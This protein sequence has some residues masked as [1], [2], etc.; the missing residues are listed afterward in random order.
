MLRGRLI[1]NTAYSLHAFTGFDG[2]SVMPILK[3][4]FVHGAVPATDIE[5]ETYMADGFEP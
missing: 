4:A 5:I 1:L 2:S 3:Q